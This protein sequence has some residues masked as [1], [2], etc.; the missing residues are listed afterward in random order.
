MPKESPVSRGQS[1]IRS[2]NLFDLRNINVF[3]ILPPSQRCNAKIFLTSQLWKL[4]LIVLAQKTSTDRAR[5][6]RRVCCKELS[7]CD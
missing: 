4:P 2:Q 6:T 7:L 5:K 3:I 1:F